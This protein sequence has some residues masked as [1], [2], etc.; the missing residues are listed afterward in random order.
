VNRGQVIDHDTEKP[1]PGVIVV[2]IYEGGRG[3][4]GASACNRVE[5]TVSDENGWFTLPLDPKGGVL[6][7]EG[8]HREYRHGYPVRVPTCGINDDPQ[9]CQVWQDRR[10]END[11]V[12]SIVKEPTIYRG[13][14]EADKAARYRRDL[15]MKRFVGDRQKRLDELRRLEGATSC[16]APPKTSEG[17]VP[18]LEAILKEQTELGESASA[19]R[20]TNDFLGWARD[21]LQRKK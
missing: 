14:A 15:Y 7:M 13:K 4:E 3:F 6:I 2:G 12:I 20:I 5:S 1:I 10:D 17:L 21:A 18:F 16:G 8:Y 19:I 9:Q 11:Q